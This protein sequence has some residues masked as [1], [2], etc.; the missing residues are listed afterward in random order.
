MNLEETIQSFI[1]HATIH[2]DTQHSGNYRKGNKSAALLFALSDEIHG[3]KDNG[4]EIIDRLLEQT[5]PGVLI[6]ASGLA[7]E[8]NY[9]KKDAIHILRDLSSNQELG[10]QSHNAEMSLTEYKKKRY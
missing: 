2:D 7:I 1:K 3:D 10:I 8:M 5:N 4:P 6:W 9:R